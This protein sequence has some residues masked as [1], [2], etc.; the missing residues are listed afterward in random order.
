[1]RRHI[2]HLKSQHPRVRSRAAVLGATGITA[3]IA[4][5][6]VTTLP[7]RFGGTVANDQNIDNTAS[8][9]SAFSDA[10]APNLQGARDS[11]KAVETGVKGLQ[12]APNPESNTQPVRESAPDSSS[13]Y[14]PYDIGVDSYTGDTDTQSGF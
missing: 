6:W 14:N 7:V 13:S 3:L 10:V 8:A 9:I 11:Y 5:I 2:E 12:I 4:V 1:M